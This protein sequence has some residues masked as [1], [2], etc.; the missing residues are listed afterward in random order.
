MQITCQFQIQDIK[1]VKTQTG[2]KAVHRARL[3]E[4]N[5]L[6]AP[7]EIWCSQEVGRVGDQ[8]EVVSAEGV[9]KP[10]A[11]N[12]FLQLP[13]GQTGNIQGFRALQLHIA[14]PSDLLSVKV[15]I[16]NDEESDNG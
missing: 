1:F 5:R 9:L 13:N 6:N 10:H 14:N 2:R 7:I 15:K 3:I 11:R 12:T 16:D 8:F 4:G